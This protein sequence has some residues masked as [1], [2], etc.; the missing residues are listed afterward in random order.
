[1]KKY[2]DMTYS[3]RK[4]GRLTKE[5]VNKG[6]RSCIYAY[7][8][9][10][11]YQKFTEIRN[12]KNKGIDL[13]SSITI[14]QWS[15][16]WLKT[17]KSNKQKATYNMYADAIRLYIKP[18]LGSCR[19]K[20]LKEAD[21]L[22]LLNK[23]NDKPRQREIV[24]LTIKQI[25]ETAVDNNY[26]YK[27]VARQIR[28]PK[29]KAGEKKPLSSKDI[30][31]IKIASEDNYSCFMVLLMIYT[32]LR[33]EEI[34]ALFWD[35]FDFINKTIHIHQAIHWEHNKPELKT[36]KNEETAYLPILDV[37]YDRLKMEYDNRNTNIV[38]P[39]KTN[40]NKIMTASSI[41]KSLDSALCYINKVK[42]K[43]E[44][45]KDENDR[46]NN[47]IEFSYHIL[48]H[49]YSCLLHKADVPIKE[50]QQLTRHKDV[51]VLL[52]IYTHLDNEDKRHATNRL[53]SYINQDT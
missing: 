49:T 43:I 48:R 18:E 24:L 8:P 25:L 42:Q 20:T 44:S 14:S 10:D 28:L 38:F 39:M 16:D 33:K 9:Q 30:E 41:R 7:T 50:A 46:D 17:Y 35:D 29:H 12:I 26:I 3:V 53:N 1:M 36:I 37:V 52:N 34:G 27:N 6:K 23:L 47:P 11:L 13:E 51:Q 15:D 2:K 31:Y 21:I 45:E 4:D 40:K 5:I 19:L 22:Q 32:G